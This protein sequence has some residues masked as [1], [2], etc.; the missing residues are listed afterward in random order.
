MTFD[1]GQYLVVA[2]D[3]E[4]KVVPTCIDE[5]RQRAAISRAYYA[6]FCAARE[7]LR[8]KGDA[9]AEEVIAAHAAVAKAFK[10]NFGK[11]G[12]YTTIGRLLLT[13]SEVR[14]RADY[15][16]EFPDLAANVTVI[17]SNADTVFQKLETLR[18]S[19]R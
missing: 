19:G 4:A 8:R 17:F 12:N 7:H 1:W 15:E 9:A 11:D 16:S 2:R 3:L 10:F 14:K 13:M 6:A 18:Q 5:A